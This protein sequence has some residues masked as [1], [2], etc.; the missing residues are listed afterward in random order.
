M[1]IFRG[2]GGTGN[3]TDDGIL[4]AV[5]A[6]AVIA[7]DKATEAASSAANAASSAT[8]ATTKASQA[9]TSATSAASSASSAASSATNASTSASSASTSASN[10]SSSATTATTKASE[11]S[12][13]ASTA[14]TKA[15]EA[16]T[17]ATNAASSATSATS[18]AST[19]TTKAGEASTSATNAAS[20][21]TSATSS[22]STATTKAS[23]ASTSAASAASS[24]DSFDDRYLGAKSSAPSVDNDGDALITG[25]LY[26]DTSSNAMKV[27]SG[28]AWL[29]AYASLSGALLATNNLSDLNNAGT[30]RTNL[31]LGTAATTA[32]SAY[33]TAAQGTTADNALPKSGGAMT[34]AITTNSTFDG[35]D[36]SADGTKLDTIATNAD[37]TNTTSVTAA[38]ALM[39]SEVTNLAQVKAFSS[40]DYATAAQGTKADTAHGWGNHASAGYLTSHQDISGKLNLSGGS[41]TGNLS[42]NSKILLASAH[43]KQKIEVYG[44]GDEWI[45]TSANQLELSGAGINLNGAGG[46]GTA[47]FKMGGTT[48]IDS[49]RNLSNIGTA[50]F[51]SNVNIGTFS[52]TGTGSL[53]LNGSTANKQARLHCTNGNLHID[54][55]NGHTT[56]LNY[57]EGSGTAF[58]NGSNGVVAWMGNDGDLWKGSSDNSG[59]KYWHSGNDGSGSGLDADTVD[60]IQGSHIFSA[61]TEI[62]SNQ[63]LNNYR[64]TGYYN[65]NSNADAASGSNYPTANAGMLE[66]INDDTGNG[67]HTVQRYARYNN[68]DR[69]TRY[70]YNGTWGAW[71]LE[72]NNLNDGSGSGLDA[73]T[74]DGIQASS[75]LRSDT[76]DSMT[77]NLDVTGTIKAIHT[78]STHATLHGYG[79]V[80]NRANNYLRPDTDGTKALYIGGADSSVDWNKIF[81]KTVNGTDVTGALRLRGGGWASGIDSGSNIGIALSK[82]NY[83]YSD[84]GNYLRNIIGHESGGLISIGQSGTSL[85]S[86]IKLTAGASGAITAN[87]QIIADKPT[88]TSTGAATIISKGSVDTTSGYNP[89]NYHITFQDGGGT[90]RGYISSSHYSTQYM[91]SSDYRLKEDIQPI[92]NATA[93]VLSLKPCNFRWIDGQERNNGFIAHELQELVPEAVSGVKDGTVTDEDGNVT[94]E[95]QGVDQS[96]LV[97][98]L[99]KTIQELE[100]RITAL[101]AN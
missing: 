41:L 27:W 68:H 84:D 88:T 9:S 63:N 57:Y 80:F 48:V 58:G 1:G 85:I 17:S 97:P 86:G 56:Y 96:K 76:A 25:A 20:S 30:A 36:V 16:S 99:V 79:I 3:S 31:G 75:F 89:Q 13:S 65:Q 15:S 87:S 69:Y 70:Y 71:S 82:G 35:R 4:D 12:T 73:D 83:I 45:G 81:L 6:Q 43:T 94:P 52:N 47:N 54:A 14:T 5:S 46:S 39:D 2:V 11:A 51:N 62:P 34:G 29:N 59:S 95:Y 38:G 32:S 53:Y 91:T 8:N 61:G 90:V 49:S 92:T 28:S 26:F 33:A 67:L 40:S 77:G 101:E 72:W 50:D 93:T 7:T 23:E 37:V 10:A 21:A 64:T 66:V 74:V 24:Y 55:E 18:S 60:G 100:A 19:A 44:G 42:T 22:A 98:L 78:D